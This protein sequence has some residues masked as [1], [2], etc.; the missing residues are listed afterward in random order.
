MGFWGGIVIGFIIGIALTVV[1]MSLA[2]MVKDSKNVVVEVSN[3][4][5]IE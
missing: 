1:I 3:S 2:I 5:D 4:T